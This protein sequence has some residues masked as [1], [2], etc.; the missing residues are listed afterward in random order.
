MADPVFVNIPAGEWTKIATNVVTGQVHKVLSIPVYMQTYR[1]TGGGAPTL[2]TD[3]VLAFANGAV[4][5][6]VSASAAI[7]V[8][9]WCVGSAGRVRVDI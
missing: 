8:Y 4:T 7:D 3:G 2:L 9:L 1:L 6:Q 5:D